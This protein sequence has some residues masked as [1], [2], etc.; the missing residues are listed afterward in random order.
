[1]NRLVQELLKGLHFET[2]SYLMKGLQ[3][4]S[5]TAV[6]PSNTL[7]SSHSTH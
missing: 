1:M 2:Q 3:V 4:I 7:L 5:L 6:E